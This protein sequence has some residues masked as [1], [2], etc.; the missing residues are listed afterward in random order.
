MLALKQLNN[1]S[2]VSF[3]SNTSMMLWKS[4][5]ISISKSL[6]SSKPQQFEQQKIKVMD[7]L[8]TLQTRST[9]TN[10]LGKL[11]FHKVLFYYY[12]HYF[13]HVCFLKKKKH[14]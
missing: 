10:C 4:K 6:S 14:E 12:F 5:S 9:F 2:K 13:I 1:I 8:N 11:E 7:L 3:K